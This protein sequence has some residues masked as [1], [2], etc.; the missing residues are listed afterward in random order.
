M[1]SSFVDIN[2]YSLPRKYQFQWNLRIHYQP[3]LPI[4]L[5]EW[6]GVHVEFN[7]TSRI[8]AHSRILP[9]MPRYLPAQRADDLCSSLDIGEVTV[10][11]QHLCPFS[12]VTPFI[13]VDNQISL[14]MLTNEQTSRGFVADYHNVFRDEG[15]WNLKSIYSFY[16]IG[17]GVGYL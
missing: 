7:R 1:K 14:S 15:W 5:P 16:S 3:I 9:D 10:G 2:P 17:S 6:H 11:D 12:S 8:A 4:E 13:S